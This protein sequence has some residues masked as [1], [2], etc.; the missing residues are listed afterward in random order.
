M[1]R[2]EVKNWYEVN[3]YVYF[4]LET[5]G[6]SYRGGDKIIEIAAYRVQNGEVVDKFST[7]VNPEKPIPPHLTENVHGISDSMVQWKE[8][9]EKVMPEF[10]NFFG[11]LPLMCHNS[12]FDISRFIRPMMK[13]MYN[14]ELDNIVLCTMRASKHVVEGVSY[15]LID[16]YKYCTGKEP[17]NEHRAEA[18]IVMGVAVANHIQQFIRSNYESVYRKAK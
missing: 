10:Y 2:E 6:F 16:M 5:T 14:Y 8:P 12:S 17:A 1:T 13:D 15:K 4:D 11:S 3:D 9:I 7:L 18:D